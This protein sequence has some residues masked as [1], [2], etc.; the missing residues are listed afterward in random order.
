MDN[1]EELPLPLPESSDLHEIVRE[2]ELRR[3]YRYLYQ[4]RDDPPTTVEIEG[5]LAEI[6]GE[7]HSQRGRRVRQLYPFFWIDKIPNGRRPPRYYLRARKPPP[8]PEG[9]RVD[10]KT[11]AQVLQPQRCAMC[12]RTPLGDGVKKLDVD[13]KLPPGMGGRHE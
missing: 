8:R 13:H 6:T 10:R 7:H 11:R 9:P 12:G 2:Q 5:Y 3:I 1:T 4:R